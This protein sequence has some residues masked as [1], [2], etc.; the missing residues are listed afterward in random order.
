MI[1][2]L[3]KTVSNFKEKANI[4]AEQNI[5]ANIF[6]GKVPEDIFQLEKLNDKLTVE[7]IYQTCLLRCK[8][9]ILNLPYLDDK[10]LL[11][12]YLKIKSISM[13]AETL[14]V[15]RIDLNYDDEMV[16]IVF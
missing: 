8:S 9:R 4:P 11:Q 6:G 2:Y 7:E 1:Y 13:I 3:H 14:K 10:I 16:S 15:L 12:K 5:A